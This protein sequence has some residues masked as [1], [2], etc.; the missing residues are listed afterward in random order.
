MKNLFIIILLFIS[1]CLMAQNVPQT[2]D[3]QGRLADSNGNYLN[4]VVTVNFLIYA[5]ETAGTVL[6]SETQAVSCVNGIFHVLLGSVTSFPTDLFDNANRWLELIV[7]G[8]TLSPRTAIASVPYSLKAGDAH[9]LN[10]LNST[11]FM[12]ATTDNWVDATGDTMTGNLIVPAVEYSSPR[13][14]YLLVGEAEFVPRDGNDIVHR[15]TGNGGTY[16][17]NGGLFGLTA[18]VDV[19]VGSRITNIEFGY[20]DSDADNML[21]IYFMGHNVLGGG[22]F[23]I[24]D[25]TSSGSA[26]YG[27][28]SFNSGMPFTASD[29]I[30]YIIMVVPQTDTNNSINWPGS[31]LK[32]TGARLTYELDYAP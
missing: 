16:I 5:A 8:E 27:S 9:L 17:S 12:P 18:Q 2:I 7:S 19:P 15:A 1:L 4:S 10:G 26:G 3:Y 23:M 22:F 6:W 29:A 11:D 13:A 31:S 14:H 24:G 32:I 21:G 28:I 25:V 30:E 20:Y